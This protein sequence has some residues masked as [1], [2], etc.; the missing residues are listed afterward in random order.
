MRGQKKTR[1]GSQ[2]GL[3]NIL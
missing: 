1:K 2:E 3:E